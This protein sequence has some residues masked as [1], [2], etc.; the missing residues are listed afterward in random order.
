[1][2]FFLCVVGM[3]LVFE[4][5]PYF[6]VPDKMRQLMTVMM[7]QDDKTLRIFGAATMVIGMLILFFARRGLSGL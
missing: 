2:E 6:L 4:G 7:E 3:V 5:I 1:M